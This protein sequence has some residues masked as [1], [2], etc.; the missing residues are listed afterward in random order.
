MRPDQSNIRIINNYIA[1]PDRPQFSAYD[2]AAATGV[3][4][5]TARNTL[6]IL[7]K[8]GSIVRLPKRVS[9]KVY[10]R[11]THESD[12]ITNELK[13]KNASEMAKQRGISRQRM[14]QIMAHHGIE[15]KGLTVSARELRALTS[16]ADGE[17]HPGHDVIDGEAIVSASKKGLATAIKSG[18]FNIY[19]LTD[20]G[21]EVIDAKS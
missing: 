8:Q 11:H 5:N 6:A 7:V 16:I 4:L 21:K 13:T 3:N 19:Q 15:S 1:M 20:L 9:G 10:Y 18:R 2:V 12:A 17:P 14:S